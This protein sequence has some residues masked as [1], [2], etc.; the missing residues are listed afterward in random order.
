MSLRIASPFPPEF[1]GVVTSVIDGALAVHNELGPG[2]IEGVYSDAM[3]IELAYRNPKF[4]RQRPTTLSYRGKPLRTHRLDLVVESQIILELK[5]V[6]RLM[7]IHRSQMIGYLRASGL[8]L[9][10][11]INFNS[12]WLRGQIKRVVV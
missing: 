3:A 7:P 1:E 5:A 8:R 4:E 2:L 6:E 11:L 10:L 9:G 12:D